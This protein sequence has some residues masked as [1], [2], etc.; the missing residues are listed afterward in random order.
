MVP[1]GADYDNVLQII[2]TAFLL[3]GKNLY[4]GVDEVNRIAVA[5]LA[6]SPRVG[7][8]ARPAITAPCPYE[9]VGIE[10]H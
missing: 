8:A 9:A 4:G 5:E 1:A 7:A 6:V 3:A 10:G 2:R